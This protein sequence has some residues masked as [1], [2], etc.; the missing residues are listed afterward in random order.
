MSNKTT[1]RKRAVA[2]PNELVAE[3]AAPA[4][5]PAPVATPVVTLA[6][7]TTVKDAAALQVTLL[8]VVDADGVTIDAKSVERIDTA[9]LQ[10]LCAF[11]RDRAA[12]NLNVSWNGVPQALAQAAALLGI[13][14]LLALPER[15]P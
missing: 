7:N 2:A 15:A 1:K 4:P 9:A 14:A 5:V 6:S 11:V 12:R 10:L 3:A 8:Q 13:G